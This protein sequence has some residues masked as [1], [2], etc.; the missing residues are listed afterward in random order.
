MRKTYVASETVHHGGVTICVTVSARRDVRERA[1]QLVG[2]ENFVEVY[3]DVPAVVAAD[4]ENETGRLRIGEKAD[5]KVFHPVARVVSAR[6]RGDYEP[7]DAD[8]CHHRRG[9]ELSGGGSKID[10]RGAP[11]E[12]VRDLIQ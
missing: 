5:Q 1:R 8:G 6:Y 7:P 12:R 10:L 4:P 3:F 11:F 2:T 9:A